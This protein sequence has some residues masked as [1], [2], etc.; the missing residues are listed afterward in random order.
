[1]ICYKPESARQLVEALRG[2]V[3]F[4]LQCGTLWIH[5]HSVRVPTEESQPRNPFGDY[6]INKNA[7]ESYLLKEA[8]MSGFPA[9]VLHPGHIVGPGWIPLNPVGNFNPQVFAFCVGSTSAFVIPARRAIV[10]FI[11]EPE[12]IQ[13][14]NSVLIGTSQVCQLIGPALAGITISFFGNSITQTSNQSTVLPDAQ[15]L[16]YSFIFQG[17][18]I[19]ISVITLL[20]MEF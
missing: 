6:G 12:H 8:K 19:L 7:I 5:G 17:I 13:S 15:G 2:Q 20:M 9:T 14:A 4:Y 10:P 1:M 11:V 18:M 16:G 3:Q